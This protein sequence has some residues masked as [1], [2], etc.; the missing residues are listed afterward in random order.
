MASYNVDGEPLTRRMQ[1][2]N[3]NRGK[4]APSANVDPEPEGH[5]WGNTKAITLGK[6]LVSIV[7]GM[8][9]GFAMEKGRG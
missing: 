4:D 9:F 1:G 5:E 6:C 3:L 8:M 7:C 2:E